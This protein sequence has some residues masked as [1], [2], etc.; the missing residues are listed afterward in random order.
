[1]N[2]QFFYP[3][4][5]TA[6]WST[7]KFDPVDN[8]FALGYSKEMTDYAN[9]LKKI[10]DSGLYRELR[11]ITSESGPKVEI[12]GQELLMLA[13]NDYLGLGRCCRDLRN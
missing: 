12:D 9:E 6:C 5:K 4:H 7:H 11:K 13:S 1:M 2:N 10:R 3:L 8:L